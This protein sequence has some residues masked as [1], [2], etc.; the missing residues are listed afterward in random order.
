MNRDVFFFALAALLLG[1]VLFRR[2][3][4]KVAP[5]QA[6]AL[7]DG[8]AK[9]VDVRT[10]AEH[11]A[12]HIQGSVHIPLGELA[13]RTGEL[14]DKSAPLVV[15]CASGMRSATAKGILVRAG[16]TQV[17]DLGGMGRWPA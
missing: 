7:V 5:E 12:G 11:A 4:G 1:F 2:F 14:G 6:R 13:D 16:F 17:H 8:G 3:A 9:L 10:S 15:Y